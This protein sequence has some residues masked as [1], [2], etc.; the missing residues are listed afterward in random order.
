M[1][2]AASGALCLLFLT[3]PQSYWQGVFILILRMK[4]RRLPP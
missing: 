3:S 1:L 4:R 2:M